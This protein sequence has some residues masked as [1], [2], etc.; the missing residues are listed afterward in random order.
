M[1]DITD[2]LPEERKT[3]ILSPLII[4]INLLIR[5]LLGNVNLGL[6]AK[7]SSTPRL[8]VAYI[9]TGRFLR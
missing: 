8:M 3:D 2:T 7:R 4:D 9:P 1:D 6:I 5:M